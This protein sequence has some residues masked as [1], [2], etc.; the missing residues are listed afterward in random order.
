MYHAFAEFEM[1]V[2]AAQSRY[3]FCMIAAIAFMVCA[4]YRAQ[5]AY[6]RRSETPLAAEVYAN[7][8]MRL[9]LGG[10]ICFVVSKML[11]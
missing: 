2:P 11:F 5:V 10:L 3:P 7:G 1:S 4:A 6:R 9:G 8:A